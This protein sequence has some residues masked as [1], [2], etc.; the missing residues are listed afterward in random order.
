M[1]TNTIII[2]TGTYSTSGS[3]LVF[4]NS[5]LSGPKYDNVWVDAGA[6]SS[7]S[8]S[9][10]SSSS[11]TFAGSDNFISDVW[12][13]D[14]TTTQFVNFKMTMPDYWDLGGIKMKIA[15]LPSSGA[16]GVVWQLCAGALS[17]Q[18]SVGSSLGSTQQLSGAAINTGNLHIT[19]GSSTVVVGGTVGLGNLINFRIGRL[20]DHPNDTSSGNAHL[21]GVEIQYMTNPIVK[22]T[23]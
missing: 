23:W 14:D 16:G 13:F 5:L 17:G 21:L 11:L 1:S 12:N 4:N 3:Y 2:G 15:W 7:T 22:D 8:I 19:T 18:A 10:A 20:P 6:M 9:G